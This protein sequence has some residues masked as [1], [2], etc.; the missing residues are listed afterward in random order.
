MKLTG[1]AFINNRW[2]NGET[3]AVFEARAVDDDGN[4]CVAVWSEPYW[5][6]ADGSDNSDCCDWDSPDEL[7]YM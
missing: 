1:E 2:Y 4:E 3:V 6:K 7:I 5:S